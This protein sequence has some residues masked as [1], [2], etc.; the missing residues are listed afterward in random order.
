MQHTCAALLYDICTVLESVR[1]VARNA[2]EMTSE[3][4][5]VHIGEAFFQ[6][7]QTLVHLI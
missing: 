5:Y 1:C 4:V 3:G 7:L 6:A 2:R